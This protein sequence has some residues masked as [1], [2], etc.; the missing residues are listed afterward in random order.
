MDNR[1]SFTL[2]PAA[3]RRPFG[4]SDISALFYGQFGT[5]HNN[6]QLD[7]TLQATIAEE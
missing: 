3:F 5:W 1:N 2:D 6:G 7:T 4:L